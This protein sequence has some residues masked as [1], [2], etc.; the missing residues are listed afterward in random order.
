MF[1]NAH[2]KKK[3]EGRNTLLEIYSENE[4]EGENLFI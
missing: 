3:N 1:S 4:K 2:S